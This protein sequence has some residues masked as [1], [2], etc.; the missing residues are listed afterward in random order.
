MVINA[1]KLLVYSKDVF[2]P[3][4]LQLLPSSV[5][6]LS[7]GVVT[8][9]FLSETL[10]ERECVSETV[11]PRQKDCIGMPCRDSYVS[12][13]WG[14]QRPQ[15]HTVGV[16]PIPPPPQS[17]VSS[18]GAAFPPLLILTSSFSSFPAKPGLRYVTSSCTTVW[19]QRLCCTIK[20]WDRQPDL[21]DGMT[22]Q[23]CNLLPTQPSNKKEEQDVMD[24]VYTPEREEWTGRGPVNEF[25]LQ[26]SND[27]PAPWQHQFV[28]FSRGQVWGGGGKHIDDAPKEIQ[29]L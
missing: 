23:H 8:R 1:T 17:V 7:N 22:E 9:S 15:I 3:S 28:L 12:L 27:L 14:G 6:P 25:W 2:T 16:T 13:L 24:S 19:S 21:W 20:V 5:F 4:D 29:F 18:L 11:K 10:R 26:K